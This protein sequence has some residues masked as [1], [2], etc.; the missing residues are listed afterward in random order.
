MKG[1]DTKRVN[2]LEVNMAEFNHSRSTASKIGDT[3][4]ELSHPQNYDSTFL[5]LTQREE[6]K[7]FT[8]EPPQQIKL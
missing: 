4:V 6:Q 2:I 8:C 7:N 5:K 1:K 3:L